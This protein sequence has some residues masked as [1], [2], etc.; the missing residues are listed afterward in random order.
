M[1]IIDDASGQ[2]LLRDALLKKKKKK[3]ARLL[4]DS[5]KPLK[6]VSAR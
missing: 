3:T 5:I 6:Q 4:P 2:M 1:T